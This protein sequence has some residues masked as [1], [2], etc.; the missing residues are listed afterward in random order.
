MW[1]S[2]RSSS[3]SSNASVSV[4]ASA[5]PS[6]PAAAAAR[7]PLGRRALDGPGRRARPPARS[8]RS[9]RS[10]RHA[11]CR[12]ARCDRPRPRAPRL[13]RTRSADAWCERAA[14]SAA[15]SALARALGRPATA[16]AACP[17]ARAARPA[18]SCASSSSIARDPVI[19]G[20]RDRTTTRSRTPRAPSRPRRPSPAGGGSLQT[21]APRGDRRRRQ[22]ASGL[23]ADRDP[24]EPVGRKLVR[25]GSASSIA[26]A[27]SASIERREHARDL[28]RAQ[29][30]ALQVEHDLG[31]PP[32]RPATSPSRFSARAIARRIA[33]PRARLDREQVHVLDHAD[34]QSAFADHRRVLDPPL[35]HLEQDLAAHPL[36]RDRVCRH[37]HHRLD[38]GV[39]RHPRGHDPAGAG[40][41]SVTMP[42]CP[43]RARPWP[44]S[45]PPRS[46][47]APPRRSPSPA[48]TRPSGCGSAWPRAGVRV[49]APR[50]RARGCTRGR[51][52]GERRRRGSGSTACPRPPEPRSPGG[53]PDSIAACPNVSPGPSRSSSLP[54]CTRSTAPL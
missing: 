39:R 52:A 34:Q 41:L 24:D 12:A 40:R 54:S 8:R 18:P 10:R 37:R 19:R 14:R 6:T 44:R 29:I 51:A 26:R 35:E 31:Q 11:G 13:R 21:T 50:P 45:R 25:A 47:G 16:R 15:S 48:R 23:A 46:S 36:G 42:S 1:C 27:V 17:T 49:R 38:R 7:E 30:R 5:S 22:L 33:E 2:T 28:E 43:S 32:P 20:A 3:A 4:R 9:A 53:S